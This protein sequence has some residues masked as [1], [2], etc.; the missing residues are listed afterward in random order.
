[1]RRHRWPPGENSRESE[2]PAWP[3]ET[4]YMV[5]IAWELMAREEEAER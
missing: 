1:M 5:S 2:I 4:E 3:Q